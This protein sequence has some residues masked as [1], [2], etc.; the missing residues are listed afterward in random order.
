MDSDEAAMGFQAHR[1]YITVLAA[2]PDQ[3]TLLTA[4]SSG[5]VSL[6]D[7]EAGVLLEAWTPPAPVTAAC[8]ADEHILILTDEAGGLSALAW[9]RVN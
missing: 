6:W 5:G 1:A 7:V 3:R 9:T 2:H 8:W 4:D